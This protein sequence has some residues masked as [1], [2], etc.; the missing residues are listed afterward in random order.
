LTAANKHLQ[1][2]ELALLGVLENILTIVIG[3]QSP[4]I[5]PLQAE[6]PNTVELDWHEN[7]L[8]RALKR[9]IG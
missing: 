2:K 3:R 8:P 1:D 6:E 4:R 7:S 9:A 5:A